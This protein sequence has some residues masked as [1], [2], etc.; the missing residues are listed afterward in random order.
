MLSQYQVDVS[1]VVPTKDEELVVKKFIDWCKEGFVEAG[2]TGEIIFADNSSDATPRIAKKNGAKV[3]R[4]QKP[5]VG[6]AYREI[7]PHISGKVVILGDADCTYD[8][9][10]ISNFLNQIQEGYDFV[11]GSRFKGNI[12]KG[13]MPI[14]HRYFGTPLTTVF[15][16]FIHGVQ[17]SDI[18]CGMRAMPTHIY[19]QILPQELGWQYASEMLAKVR[20]Q[21]LNYIEIPINFY[22]APSNRQSHL[23]RSGWKTPIREGIGTLVTTFKY[24]ADKTLKYLSLISLGLGIPLFIAST[25]DL[26]KFGLKQPTFGS[27]IAAFGLCVF[28]VIAQSLASLSESIYGMTFLRSNHARIRLALNRTFVMY[29]FLLF[30]TLVFCFFYL[31]VLTKNEWQLPPNY[32]YMSYLIAPVLLFNFSFILQILTRSLKLFI[33]ESDHGYAKK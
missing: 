16:N 20:H 23:K 6:H 32:Y 21:N 7:S 9:R 18:H 27:Q 15:F 26:S 11:I 8:F 30:C 22:K 12:E 14:V 28:G 33:L 1:I 3:V 2:V 10:V 4:I 29:M 25:L 5:G 19:R 17:Y 24:G 31:F 13:S